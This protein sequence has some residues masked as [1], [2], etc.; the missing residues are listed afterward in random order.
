MIGNGN[1]KIEANEV[2][3]VQVQRRA[4][5]AKFDIA[6]GT[7]ISDEMLDFLRPCPVGALEPFRKSDVIG[8]KTNSLIKKGDLISSDNIHDE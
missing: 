2:N 3:T 7:K 5:R 8:K 6:A 1:K 4:I